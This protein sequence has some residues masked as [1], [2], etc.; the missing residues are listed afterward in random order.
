MF[1]KV[2]HPKKYYGERYSVNINWGILIADASN[3]NKYGGTPPAFTI[4]IHQDTLYLIFSP[5]I[6]SLREPVD[7][8]FE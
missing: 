8:I 3:W 2:A 7:S 6:A 5:L 1:Y 4:C